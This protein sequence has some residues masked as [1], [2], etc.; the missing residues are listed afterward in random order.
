MARPHIRKLHAPSR[1]QR[2]CAPG[3]T[4]SL[5]GMH[6]EVRGVVKLPDE[7]QGAAEYFVMAKRQRFSYM[8]IGL[9]L[10]SEVKVV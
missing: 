8:Y 9:C 10:S 5:L 1:L 6:Y 2:S 7:V 3:I 4:Y